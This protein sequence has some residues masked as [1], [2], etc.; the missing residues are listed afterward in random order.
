MFWTYLSLF[1]TAWIYI[2]SGALRDVMKLR[3]VPVIAAL[4]PV[5]FLIAQLGFAIVCAAVLS[6]VLWPLHSILGI[7]SWGIMWPILAV[8][9]KY[10]GKIFAHYLMQ[11][12]A[13]TARHRGAYDPELST[14]LDAF[15]HNIEQA[16]R[17]GYDE[18]LVV[19]HS[20]GAHLGFTVL[21]RLE[22]AGILSRNSPISFLSLGHV[23]PM[24][25]FLPEATELRSDLKQLGNSDAVTWVDVT[26]PGDG[27]SIA[28]C[29]PV[30]VSGQGMGR[31]MVLWSFLRPLPKPCQ[32][33]VGVCCD[34]GF[35]VYIS[36]ICAPLTNL[37]FM[38]TFRSLQDHVLC[39]IAFGDVPHHHRAS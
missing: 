27:C 13:H 33:P 4:Y 11:D 10:D 29:D 17:D 30:A 24:V 3:K 39:A 26:A 36:S 2:S 14:R 6:S 19:G 12:Y 28:L 5:G 9:Q 32:M 38:I 8:F 23:V 22:R 16:L 20:S 31:K 21:A 18:I 1:K 37:G 34:G 25:S 7:L 35:S 15:G